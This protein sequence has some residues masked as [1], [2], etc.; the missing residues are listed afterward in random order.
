MTTIKFSL[1]A[2]TGCALMLALCTIATSRRVQAQDGTPVR[3]TNTPVPIQNVVQVPSNL[4]ELICYSGGAG[5]TY[6]CSSRQPDG[7]LAYSYKVPS[8]NNLI[9]TSVEIMPKVPGS[10]IINVTLSNYVPGGLARAEW[11]VPNTTTTLLQYPNGI[12]LSAG[13][14]PMTSGVG[15]AGVTDAEVVLRGYLAPYVFFPMGG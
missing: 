4:I 11:K 12:V 7:H 9:I 13:F 10:G 5:A 8:S 6:A 15:V 2:G 3:V 14:A 1:L